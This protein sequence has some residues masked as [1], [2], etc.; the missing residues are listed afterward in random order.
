[1]RKFGMLI[2]TVAICWFA[3][4]AAEAAELSG[5]SQVTANAGLSLSFSGGGNGDATF[6]LIGPSHVSKRTI[7]SGEPIAIAPEEVRT[8]GRY[9]ALL[10]SG[11]GVAA[12]VFYVTPAAP[13]T[14]NFLARPS[15]VPAARQGV[16]SGVAFVFD[17]Y[18]NLVLAPTPVKFDLAVAGA[19]AVS[20][21]VPSQQG[22]AWVRMDSGRTQGAAQFVA[23]LPS[24][25]AEEAAS[26]RRVVQ[27]VAADACNL[28]IRAQRTANNIVV[29]T[30]PVRDCSGNAV[31]DGTIITF[32]ELDSTGRSTVDARVKRDVARAELPLS[33]DATI[34]VASGVVVGNELH[35][36]GGR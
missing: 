17:D 9:T 24:A 29:E 31:P 33:N 13:R 12:K 3:A 15:R 34:S 18:K 27:Q 10:R 35:I 16:I 28:R 11:D 21:N 30:D 36:G 7:K 6:Y 32:T 23:S 2:L 4:Y 1:M 25:G 20:R 26:V 5:P 14:L 22:I 8:A 19:G